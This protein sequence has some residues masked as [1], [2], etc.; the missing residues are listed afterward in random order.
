MP[1]PWAAHVEQTININTVALRSALSAAE[2]GPEQWQKPLPDNFFRPLP[3]YSGI[4][5]TN[6][7]YGSNYHSMLFT[8]NRRF[9]KGLTMGLS[10]TFSKYL[11]YSGIPTYQP[12]RSWAYGFNGS[13][14]THNVA[15][16]YT[17][18][19]AEGFQI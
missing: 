17:Y 14:Q 15:I 7:A 16:N 19:A 12:L 8:I 6:A 1:A 5:M 11:D 13:D 18:D 3:G 2:R 10:Y 9:S 4:T